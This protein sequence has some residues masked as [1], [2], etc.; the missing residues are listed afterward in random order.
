MADDPTDQTFTR[1]VFVA[2]TDIAPG[3]QRYFRYPEHG[4]PVKDVLFADTI[5]APEDLLRMERDVARYFPNHGYEPMRLC[6]AIKPFSPS[7]LAGLREIG[8]M[9]IRRRALNKLTTEER[10]ALGLKE[11]AP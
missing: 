4:S 6:V 7:A 3:S 9:F 5:T 1:I 10:E 11:A 2:P 8:Q